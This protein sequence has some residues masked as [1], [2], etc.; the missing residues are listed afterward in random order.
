MVFRTVGSSPV[1]KTACKESC[2][3]CEVY[4]SLAKDFVFSVSAD[5]SVVDVLVSLS[6]KDPETALLPEV[7]L[8]V[9]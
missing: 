3:F 4:N 2:W 6:V 9:R 8:N 7:V 1:Q 5:P